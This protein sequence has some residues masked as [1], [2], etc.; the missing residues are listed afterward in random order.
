MS[1][2]GRFS[3]RNSRKIRRARQKVENLD[4]VVQSGSSE[5]ERLAQI[6]LFQVGVVFE[7]FFAI[8]IAG[9]DV[10]DVFDGN[11]QAT[12][13]GFAAQFA[14]FDGDA[15]ERGVEGHELIVALQ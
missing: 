3:P 14:R 5:R 2:A 9:E 8:G 1:W 6:L 7:Q 10:Q 13:A 15:V 11:A 12:N 4:P